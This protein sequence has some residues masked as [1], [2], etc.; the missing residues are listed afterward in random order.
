MLTP[1]VVT[2]HIDDNVAYRKTRRP[3]A[4]YSP[5]VQ[6][7]VEGCRADG[8]EEH[9]IALLPEIFSSGISEKALTW[10]M[11]REEARK[12]HNGASAQVYRMFLHSDEA[13]RSHCRLCS[14]DANQNGWKNAKDVLRHLKRDHFGLVNVCPRWLVQTRIFSVTSTCLPRGRQRQ[15]CVHY[16][17]NVETSV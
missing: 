2:P 12:H 17:R 15:N 7:V 9:A 16:W 6:V 8:G 14:V 3:P 11:T 5:D 13:G 10:K 1:T 4:A